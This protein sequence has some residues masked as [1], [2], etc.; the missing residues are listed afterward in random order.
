MEDLLDGLLALAAGDEG[1]R[2]RAPV[3]L[4]AVA[5]RASQTA[6]R[7]AREHGIRLQSDVG[8]AAVLG[9]EALVERL[10][11]NLLENAVRHNRLGGSAQLTVGSH[12]DE[13]FVRV[14]NEGPVVDPEVLG[15]LVEP[16]QRADRARG[17][18]GLGLSIVQAVARAH[19]GS[20][21]LR[22]RAR[23]GLE[24]EVRLPALTES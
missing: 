8:E 5:R 7:E 1:S 9:D 19:G 23:G 2:R 16:F 20:L 24:A 17:G 22:A 4:A 10:V 3:D 11:S 13:A 21:R 18:S 15:R 12:D 14:V 6:A